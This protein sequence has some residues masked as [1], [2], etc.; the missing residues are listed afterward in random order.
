V[1]ALSGLKRVV[2]PWLKV[3]QDRDTSA[4]KDELFSLVSQ[5]G[6]SIETPSF[7]DARETNLAG[8][9]IIAS[10]VAV[11]AT[12]PSAVESRHIGLRPEEEPN[13]AK[14]CRNVCER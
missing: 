12:H 6:G 8:A 11:L 10:L 3:C 14:Q 4:S 13:I 2:L 7:I 9:L 1:E 5:P